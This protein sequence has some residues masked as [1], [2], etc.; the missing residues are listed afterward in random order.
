MPEAHEIQSP[1]PG[2]RPFEPH[3]AAIFFGRERHVGRLL[4][5]LLRERFLAVIGPSG[6]GKSSL[7]RAG[8]L[9]ALA[10]GFLGTGGAWRIAVMRPGDRPLRQL[11]RALVAPGALGAELLVEDGPT[12]NGNAGAL[13]IEAELRRGSLGLVHLVEDARVRAAAGP[14]FDLL[15]LVDQFEELFRYAGQGAPQADESDAFVD[16]LLESRSVESAR[17]HVV[18][19][20]RSDF[21]GHCVRFLELP[22][23]INRAQYLTPRLTREQLASAIREPARVFGG[24]VEPELVNDVINA[25]S[26]DPD[27]LPI[28]QHALARVWDAALDR[29]ARAPMVSRSDLV[30]RGGIDGAL[31]RHADEVLRSLP[32]PLQPLVELLFRAV[33]EGGG[34]GEVRYV[35]RPRTLGQVAGATGHAWEEFVP[36][37]E[38]FAREGVNFLSYV[39]PLDAGSTIDISHE[40]LIRQWPRLL[41]WAADEVERATDYRRWRNRALERERGGELLAG[42]DL[43]RAREWL[44]GTASSWTPTAEWAARYAS[45]AGSGAERDFER[46]V[47]LIEESGARERAEQEAAEHAAAQVRKNERQRLEAEARAAE[48]RA[49]AE[50]QRAEAERQETRLAQKRIRDLER[51]IAQIPDKAKRQ[52]LAKKYLPDSIK[53]L[54]KRQD[55]KLAAMLKA[56]D[57][58]RAR[59]RVPPRPGLKLWENGARLRVRFL[60]GTATQTAQ[61]KQQAGEWTKYANMEFDFVKR[62]DAEIRV[63]F[64]A[65]L[66][67]W[68]YMGTDALAIPDDQPTM[69]LGWIAENVLHELGH[70]LGLIH[71]TNNPNADLPWN[72]PVVYRE[73]QG[74][75]NNWSRQQIDQLLFEKY[76]DLEYRPYDPESIM[77]YAHPSSWFTDGREVKGGKTLSESDKRFI[78]ELYPRDRPPK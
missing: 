42:A 28:L 22:E 65:G 5:I 32:S 55:K 69:N 7:V 71:E 30:A 72:K 43:A 21:L 23:A 60:G 19:A 77:S 51:V 3:E 63:S 6:S 57:S 25:V 75:P 58:G 34:D 36:V 67:S 8:M 29:N 62:R 31:S 45:R 49:E 48:A 4:E 59:P 24:D 17:I 1:Y 74:P 61:V 76:K 40:A 68:A 13:P 26:G 2:L 64:D 10:A 18:M 46:T 53:R 39:R 16:L 47:A 33:T 38:A 52:A 14:P 66:G 50:R 41:A 11:A 27:Q 54:S 9:P 20:M 44:Q 56:D 12:A 35:R 70:V 37:V 15:V 78:A 73:L